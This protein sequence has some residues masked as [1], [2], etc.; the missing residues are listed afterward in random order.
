MNNS[1]TEGS[2]PTL[3]DKFQR[4]NVLASSCPSRSILQDVTSRWGV[5]VLFALLQGTHR[6]SELRKA[7]A[8]V[9]EKM[10]SQTLHALEADGFVLRTAHPVIPPHV[11]YSLTDSGHEVANRVEELVNWIEVNINPIL[12]AR[13]KYSSL[14]SD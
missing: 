4:G 1:M 11:E 6:F 12:S 5:L 8:G 7:I 2:E 14:K 13:D 3:T 10:L 9:S